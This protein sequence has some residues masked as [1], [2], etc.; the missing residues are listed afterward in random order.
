M[1][2]TAETAMSNG[3]QSRPKGEPGPASGAS[4]ASVRLVL[5]VVGPDRGGS[6]PHGWKLKRPP[7]I[8]SARRA[9]SFAG[10]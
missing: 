5:D 4:I 6:P 10:Y 2:T 7:R 1:S 3:F 9:E 8:R